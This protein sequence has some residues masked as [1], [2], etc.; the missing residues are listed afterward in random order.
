MQ[1]P[2]Y[3]IKWTVS[4]NHE[5]VHL[6]VCLP[7]LDAIGMGNSSSD[8]AS[9]GQSERGKEARP[10]ILIDSTEDADIFQRED[11]K[12]TRLYQCNTNTVIPM[13]ISDVSFC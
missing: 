4:V 12:V 5:W 6:F 7:V 1:V 2:V 10:N 11:A 13:T 8:R 9:G 3:L